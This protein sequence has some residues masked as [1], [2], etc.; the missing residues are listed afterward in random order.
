MKKKSLI[1]LFLIIISSIII[2]QNTTENDTIVKKYVVAV[3]QTPPFII[4][5]ANEF[6]GA[7]IDLWQRIANDLNIVY[8][9]KEYKQTDFTIMLDDIEAGKVDICINPLTVSSERLIRFDYTLPFYSSHLAIVVPNENKTSISNLMSNFFTKKFFKAISLL[10]LIITIIGFVIWL[11]EKKKNNIKFR[12]GIKGWGDGFWWA[13]VTMT[14]V[15]YGDRIPKSTFGRIFSIIWMFT[16]V[17]VI[18]SLTGSIA[19]SLTVNEMKSHINN[20]EDVRKLDRIGTMKGTSSEVFLINHNLS[21]LDNDFEAIIDGLYA[22]DNNNID[23]F[24]YDEAII[25][26]LISANNL[27]SQLKILPY[28]INV[29]YYSFALPK[30]NNDLLNQLNTSLVEELESVIWIGILNKYGLNE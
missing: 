15:G 5:T 9:F 7:S 30:N 4:K 8:E 16:S 3:K 12:K 1:F 26:Y 13:A 23:A 28:K 20:L 25:K 19:A 6:S 17:I 24:I 2:A 27:N 14:T 29:I 22:V 21:N 10:L 11:V 18:S